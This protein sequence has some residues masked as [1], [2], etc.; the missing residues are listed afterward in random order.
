[1][2]E[3]YENDLKT[4]G[5]LLLVLALVMLALLILSI[6]LTNLFLTRKIPATSAPYGRRLPVLPVSRTSQKH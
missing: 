6:V 5:M 2:G 1:M 4:F 3:K